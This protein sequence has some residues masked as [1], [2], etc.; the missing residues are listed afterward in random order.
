V[1]SGK[2]ILAAMYL[3]RVGIESRSKPTQVSAVVTP[4]APAAQDQGVN[5]GRG[6]WEDAA[7]AG[8]KQLGS[9]AAGKM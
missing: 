4:P 3:R 8:D 9:F 1:Y 5:K 2:L 6:G 7:A